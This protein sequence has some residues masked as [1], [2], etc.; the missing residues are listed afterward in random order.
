MITGYKKGFQ[1]E[2]INRED[3][4]QYFQFNVLAANKQNA[5]KKL[6]KLNVIAQYGINELDYRLSVKEIMVW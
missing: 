4:E 6:Y 3:N 1:F 2:Y 5:Y